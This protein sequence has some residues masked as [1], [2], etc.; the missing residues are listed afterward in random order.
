VLFSP[1]MRRGERDGQGLFVPFGQG[2][3]RATT[4]S[5]AQVNTSWAAPTPFFR[6]NE[7]DGT[8]VEFAAAG[9]AA[10]LSLHSGL[11]S[12]Y[13]SIAFFPHLI[14]PWIGWYALPYQLQDGL[15]IF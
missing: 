12:L 2:W 11:A 10:T 6:M 4:D 9:K 13:L 1:P 7:S 5:R 14:F 15:R 8:T 3:Q